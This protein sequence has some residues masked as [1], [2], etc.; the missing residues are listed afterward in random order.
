M[1]D[2]LKNLKQVKV[3]EAPHGSN[4]SYLAEEVVGLTAAVLTS[5]RLHLSDASL[6]IVGGRMRF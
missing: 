1:S 4:G 3:V 5:V 6:E 2:P